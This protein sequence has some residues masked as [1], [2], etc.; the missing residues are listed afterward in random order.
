MPPLW[1]L[2][3]PAVQNVLIDGSER[4]SLFDHH[5]CF[6]LNIVSMCETPATDDRACQARFIYFVECMSVS[7]YVSMCLCVCVSLCRCLCASVPLCLC[8]SVPLCLCASVSLCVCASVS[9]C[10]CASV[11]L[12]VCAPVSLCCLRL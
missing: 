1:P 8:A 2:P 5:F 9:L 11:R 4:Q 3:P 10:V 6:F 7:V 12:C